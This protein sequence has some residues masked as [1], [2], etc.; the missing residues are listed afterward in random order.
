MSLVMHPETSRLVQSLENALPQ[1]ILLTGRPGVGLGSL[2]KQ[3]AKHYQ[4]CGSIRPQLLTKSSTSIQIG[5][6][7]I[8]ELYETTRSK[9]LRDAVYII[10]DS[11]KMTLPAQ[12]SFLKLLEEPGANYRFILTSHYPEKLL[13]TV[14]SRCQSFHI[15]P[16]SDAKTKQLLAAYPKLT[17]TKLRQIVFIANGLPA[18]I[19]RL[20]TDEKYFRVVAE[21]TILAR[22]L[23][24]ASPYERLVLLAKAKLERQDALFLCET[25][26][27]L[28]ELRPTKE[29][30]K[31]TDI[32]LKTYESLLANG[33]V[34]LQLASAMV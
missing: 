14:R 12:N 8:R 27:K 23:L 24:E 28:L 11:D 6:G 1:T 18:E 33:N 32:L 3:I 4:L 10:D 22:E 16:I 5:I 34:K 21:R 26:L 7:V 25:M 15:K 20:A 2:A 9:N 30:I 17:D 13:P 19:H 29:S 31:R